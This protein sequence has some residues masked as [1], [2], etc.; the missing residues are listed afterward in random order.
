MSLARSSYY[1]RSDPEAASL[2]DQAQAAMRAA[3]ENVVA[4][5]PFY[6]YRRVTH[7]LRRRG[8]VVN[9]KK[10]ARIM[11]EAALTPRKVRRFVATTDSDHDLPIYPDL[12]KG[13]GL[14]RPDQL[15]VA[16][17]TYIRLGTQFVYLAAILDAWSRKIVGYALGNTLETRLTL[18]ALDAAIVDRLPPEGL[19]HHSDR[20]SQYA[21][22]AYRE[23]L[24]LHG[25]R[26]SMSRKGNP[27]DNAKAESFMK[28]LKHEEVLLAGYRD[29]DDVRRRLPRFIEDVY[30]ARR[31][32]SALG[33]LPPDEFEQLHARRAVNS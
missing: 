28:T 7:E 19:I 17:L 32:H 5:W 24:D 33:Y 2:R 20:G 21:A 31:L 4:D 25:I 13:L 8:I 22:K 23:R 1:K 14:D 27:Y 30:N 11:R 29:L 15:W 3:I 26:G 16:D 6:G 18:A 9:H 12:T 10:V